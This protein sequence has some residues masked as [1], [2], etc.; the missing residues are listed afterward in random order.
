MD[1][2]KIILRQ[3]QKHHF[4]V[5]SVVTLLVALVCWW[6]GANSLASA[7]AAHES[8]V[9]K[10]FSDMQDVEKNGHPANK[11]FSKG[12]TAKHDE[13]KNKVLAEWKKRFG[14]QQKLFT[15]PALIA[16]EMARLK[17]DD[18][19][20]EDV[21]LKCK[22]NEVFLDEL[23]NKVFTTADYRH[24]KEAVAKAEAAAVAG[25]ADGAAPVTEPAAEEGDTIVGLVVWNKH[26]RAA[27]EQRY[28]LR[29]QS[30]TPSTLNIRL[31]QEDM[32]MLE[33]LAKV[34]RQTNEGAQDVIAVPIK[35]IDSLDIAQWAINDAVR[36]SPKV[37]SEGSD[38]NAGPTGAFGQGGGTGEVPTDPAEREKAADDELLNGRYLGDTGQPLQAGDAGPYAEFKLIFV[39]MKVVI[40]QRKIPELLVNCANAPLPIEVVR[41][42]MDEPLVSSGVKPTNAGGG[43]GGLAGARGGGGGLAGARG[44]LSAAAQAAPAAGDQGDEIEPNPSDV[45]VEVCGIVQLYTAPDAEK[46]GTGSAA[47]PGKRPAG[48][49]TAQ[50]KEPR[51]SSTTTGGS[52]L[53]R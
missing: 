9:K 8:E 42:R 40:D 29:R 46:L 36:E 44:G 45:T 20:P 51:A 4:W 27:L 53:K 2:V 23:Y 26:H 1:Q 50:V 17:P 6:M 35:R 15:W 37:F 10:S 7:T 13:V 43:G 22:S 41:F 16:G 5:L 28:N 31:A 14:E 3:L 33:N 21:R 52:G 39:R 48:V 25:G 24:S 12:V 19:I 18:A 30:G 34:I 49:P 38:P 47:D 11:D 32:W